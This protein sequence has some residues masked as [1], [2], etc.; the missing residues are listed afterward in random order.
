[1]TDDALVDELVLALR[2]CATH[3][4]GPLRA[5]ADCALAVPD[6]GIA[7]VEQL[8]AKVI[9]R[10]DAMEMPPDRRA[11]VI[12]FLAVVWQGLRTLAVEAD[13]DL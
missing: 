10:L 12:A 7:G 9:G 11:T 8:R 4:A 2:Q 13:V 5:V 1:M 6:L 3:S